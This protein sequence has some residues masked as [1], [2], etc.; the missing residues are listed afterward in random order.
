MRVAN[1]PEETIR[2][3]RMIYRRHTQQNA[4]AFMDY[5]VQKF[6]FRIP[7]VRTDRGHEFEALFH[8]HLADQG[9]RHLY[10]KTRTP[11]LNGKVERS[12]R[13]DQQ[14]F[15][16]LLSYTDDV[17]LAQRL[18]EWGGLLQLSPPARSLR[19]QDALRGAPKT[20]TVTAAS[21]RRGALHHTAARCGRRGP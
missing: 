3:G 20:A 8:W 7:T 9:I 21:V 11:Q 13:T 12:H 6:P 4:I 5:V 17:D 19:G 14:V 16:Q 15:Y 1:A 2:S 10:N 18:A